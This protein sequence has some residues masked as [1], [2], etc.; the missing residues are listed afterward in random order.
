MIN[1]KI[2]KQYSNRAY[3]FISI[4]GKYTIAATSF[5]IAKIFNLEIDTYNKILIEKVIKHDRY[6]IAPDNNESVFSKDLTFELLYDSL[7]TYIERFKEIFAKEL[8]L[9]A[10][11]DT[12]ESDGYLW[13]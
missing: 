9:L 3:F 6:L 5:K 11:S 2:E 1:I 13:R 8:V 10:L 12:L 4:E 7:K